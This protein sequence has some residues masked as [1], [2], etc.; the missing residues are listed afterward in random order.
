MISSEFD[1]VSYSLILIS[2][3]KKHPLRELFRAKSA[4]EDQIGVGL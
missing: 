4:D 2:T 1:M 3:F